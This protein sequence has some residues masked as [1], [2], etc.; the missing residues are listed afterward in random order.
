[1]S[2]LY[3]NKKYYDKFLETDSL[4]VINL[5]GYKNRDDFFEKIID[6]LNQKYPFLNITQLSLMSSKD[7]NT[8]QMYNGFISGDF[9]DYDEIT[10][11]FS[12]PF[13]KEGNTIISQQVMPMLQQKI[14]NDKA[15][16]FNKRIK[17]IF[18]LTSHKSTVLTRERNYINNENNSSIIQLLVKCLVTLGFDVFP[19]IPIINLDTSA[20]F[21]SLQEFIENIYYIQNLNQSNRQ[22]KNIRLI[23][24][25][26][27]GS[28]AQ[29]PIGQDE[30]YFA[31]RYLTAI[32][33]NNNNQYDVSQAYNISEKSQMMK[34][35]YDLENY[36]Q[37]NN[38]INVATQELSNYEYV[39]LVK[40]EDQFLEKIR[41]LADRYGEDGNKTI[42]SVIRLPELQ[43]ELRRRLLKKHGSKCIM[44]NIENSQLLVA[45][46]IK[47]A[48]ECNINEKK[49]SS[50]T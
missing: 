24:D 17:K 9:D 40:K 22:Y 48:C 20:G 19:F 29:K 49:L 36:V 32:M 45:S 23:G 37:D 34:M 1:M 30:K 4:T 2:I 33:L 26:V 8:Y 11:S 43:A 28:F 12:D 25:K 3:I 7:T 44:C 15:F 21:S 41:E 50:R 18:L 13:T 31:I 27:M 14:S 38:I 42:T 6:F 46:H 47:Q 39:Q 10:V 5:Y 35:L 16:L